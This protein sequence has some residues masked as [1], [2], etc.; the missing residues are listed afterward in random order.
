MR[1]DQAH[2]HMIA[3][4]TFPNW[5]R[6][7]PNTQTVQCGYRHQQTANLTFERF[8]SFNFIYFFNTVTNTSHTRHKATPHW[9]GSR[10]FK[11]ALSCGDGLQRWR[12]AYSARRQGKAESR[13]YVHDISFP[14]RDFVVIELSSDAQ[15]AKMAPSLRR[16]MPCFQASLHNIFTLSIHCST[17]SI[18]LYI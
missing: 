12:C 17:M 7:F 4:R 11:D 10:A 6:S 13:W 5:S 16:L 9:T 18:S 8:R 14:G 15:N 1:V 3:D 2:F